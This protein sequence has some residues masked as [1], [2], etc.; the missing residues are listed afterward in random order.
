M[1]IRTDPRIPMIPTPPEP[2]YIPGTRV[3]VVQ[4]VRI[5]DRRWSTEVIGMVTEEAASPR[6]RHGNG[7]QEPL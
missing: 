4:H 2:K 6:R 5:G 3:R 7:G 1:L